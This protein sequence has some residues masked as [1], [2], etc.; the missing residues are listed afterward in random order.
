MNPSA[1]TL[2]APDP[3]PSMPYI[4]PSHDSSFRLSAGTFTT[5]IMLQSFPLSSGMVSHQNRGVARAAN[6]S[7]NRVAA[8]LNFKV[9]RLQVITRTAIRAPWFG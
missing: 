2:S 6:L 1:I 7:D 4:M 8:S 3:M 5:S 9:S